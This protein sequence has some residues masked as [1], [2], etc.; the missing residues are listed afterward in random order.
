MASQKLLNAYNPAPFV[1]EN[2]NIAS[3]FE[4]NTNNFIKMISLDKSTMT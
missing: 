1:T 3:H 2:N 4:E